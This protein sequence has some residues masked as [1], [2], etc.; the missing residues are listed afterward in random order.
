MSGTRPNLIILG[1]MK[2]GTTALH[3]ALSRHPQIQ[4][5]EPKELNFFVSTTDVSPFRA[6]ELRGA[7]GWERGADWYGSH[8][9]PGVPVCGESSPNY[10]S[11]EHHGAAA[12]MASHIPDAKL[13]FLTRDPISRS[14][15]HYRHNVLEGAERRPIDEAL[16]DVESGYVVRSEYFR[17]LTPFLERF[18]REQVRVV[19]HERLRADP[20]ATLGELYEFLEV[21]PEFWDP[22][23]D[24]QVYATTARNR[25]TP[26]VRELRQ[27]GVTRRLEELCSPA[28]RRRVKGWLSRPAEGLTVTADISPRTR[29]HLAEHF[30]EDQRQLRAMIDETQSQRI[31]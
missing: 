15:S 4:M 19:A 6:R 21:D 28:A 25:Q 30:R 14:I 11:P 26:L 10:T 24:Q 16:T 3:V 9:D 13:I 31:Y 22:A 23:Q 18:P 29:E 17:C 7:F 8:F 27:L 1:A 20:Q 5:S 12:R 2:A